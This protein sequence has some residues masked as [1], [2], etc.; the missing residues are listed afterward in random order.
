MHC[1]V[2][3]GSKPIIIALSIDK[4]RREDLN[5][6]GAAVLRSCLALLSATASCTNNQ[7]STKDAGIMDTILVPP[8][9]NWTHHFLSGH[10]TK[11]SNGCRVEEV[12]PCYAPTPG[13]GPWLTMNIHMN[14]EHLSTTSFGVQQLRVLAL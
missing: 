7:E 5:H 13:P 6:G 3:E 9:F 8:W 11:S 2:G 1:L 10:K 14:N 4:F 12:F